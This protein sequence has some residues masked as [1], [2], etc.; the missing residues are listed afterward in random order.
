[1]HHQE[2]SR[3]LKTLKIFCDLFRPVISF[4]KVTIKKQ[5][6]QAEVRKISNLILKFLQMSK[7]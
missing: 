7:T 6:C 4:H 1:M 3:V 2:S 5:K